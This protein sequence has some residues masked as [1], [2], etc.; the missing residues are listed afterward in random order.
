[1]KILSHITNKIK[2]LLFFI[3]NRII[4]YDRYLFLPLILAKTGAP[5]CACFN[6]LN[7]KF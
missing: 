7:I 2:G 4:S 1:M 5:R 6:M 3:E